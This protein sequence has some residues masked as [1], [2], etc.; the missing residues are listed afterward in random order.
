MRGI[1]SANNPSPCL[2][3]YRSIGSVSAAGAGE[4]VFAMAF[5]MRQD[6]VGGLG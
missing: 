3:E 6:R 1:V 2:G 5:E 4:D